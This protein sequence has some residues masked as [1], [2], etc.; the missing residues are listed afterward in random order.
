MI[1]GVPPGY[2]WSVATE[3]VDVF[4]DVVNVVSNVVFLGLGR[5]FE[6]N[7]LPS[8]SCETEIIEL[9]KLFV[10]G[11]ICSRYGLKTP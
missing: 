11:L 1:P 7:P 4:S 5:G 6:T 9:I 2:Q 3:V 10:S 8:S